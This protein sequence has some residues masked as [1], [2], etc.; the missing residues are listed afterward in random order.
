M[1]QRPSSSGSFGSIQQAIDNMEPVG[2]YNHYE[3]T[4]PIFHQAGT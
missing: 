3:N 1:I 2:E 4:E